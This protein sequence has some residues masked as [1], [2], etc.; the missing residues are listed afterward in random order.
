M[1][2]AFSRFQCL[3]IELQW[4]IWEL[5]IPDSIIIVDIKRGKITKVTRRPH[6][7]MHICR[8][9][10]TIFL[11]HLTDI[12][13]PSSSMSI[14]VNFARDHFYLRG[15]RP[16]FFMPAP[17]HLLPNII[18]GHSALE[19]PTEL[20]VLLSK[21]VHLQQLQI[22][23]AEKPEQLDPMPANGL[24]RHCNLHHCE[25]FWFQYT[26]DVHDD[27]PERQVCPACRWHSKIFQQKFFDHGY[28]R[29]MFD[30]ALP[31]RPTTQQII[32]SR[33]P[34][35]VWVRL[36]ECLEMREERAEELQNKVE[37]NEKDVEESYRQ[38]LEATA[39]CLEGKL[40]CSH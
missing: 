31:A 40:D 22:C 13:P 9:S 3:P 5:S 35:I 39:A 6:L 20:Q 14:A 16:F 37:L 30:P 18:L 28:F 36:C 4:I 11:K 15:F 19:H 25:E 21:L 34:A 2:D 29:L 27:G 24:R 7:L 12:F 23:L 38:V 26:S 17:L 1:P 10:R 32:E 8:M 33:S